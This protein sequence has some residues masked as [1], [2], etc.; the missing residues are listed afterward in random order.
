MI[1]V[2]G[3]VTIKIPRILKPNEPDGVLTGKDIHA[4][5]IRQTDGDLPV[6]RENSVMIG[7]DGDADLGAFG[8]DN[9][10]VD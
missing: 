3:Q 4:I 9:G 10:A 7:V 2:R 5:A 8:Q 6:R 1:H